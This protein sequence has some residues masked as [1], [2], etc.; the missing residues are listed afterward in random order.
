[1]RTRNK[2]FLKAEEKVATLAEETGERVQFVVEERGRGVFVFTGRGEKWD[3]EESR[4]GHRVY[5]HASGS[6]K[7]ILATLPERR[8]EEITAEHGL[9]KMTENTITD[10]SS[11]KDELETIRDR[12]YA[13]NE[14][15]NLRGLRS[16]GVPI[17]NGHGNTVGGLSVSG[18]MHRLKGDWYRKEIPEL[19]LKAA[20]EVQLHHHDRN[21]H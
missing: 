21:T 15:E 8:V 11:L 12:G 5:L 14:E 17:V 6:G 4:V 13:F 20:N 2:A 7:A 19:A 9:P 18:P 10:V 3:R 1:L 16:V